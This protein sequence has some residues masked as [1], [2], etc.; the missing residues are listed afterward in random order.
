MTSRISALLA[1]I[2][3]AIG[4]SVAMPQAAQAQRASLGIPKTVD[5]HRTNVGLLILGHSTSEVGDYPTK[6]AQALG[7]RPAAVDGRN[8]VVFRVIQ[9]GDGGFLWNKAMYAPT[10]PLYNRILA[11]NPLQYCT[12]GAGN[13][14][15]VRRVKLARSLTGTDPSAGACPNSSAP[16]GLTCTWYDGAGAHTSSGFTT[17]WQKM[18]VKLALIQDTT[19]RSWPVDDWTGDGTMSVGDYF[20]TNRVPN[21][22]AWPCPGGASG[23]VGTQ[24]DWNC[25]GSLTVA[26]QSHRVYAGWLQSL[27][28]ALLNDFGAASVQH[29]FVTPKPLEFG[30]ACTTYTQPGCGLHATRTPTPSR[31]FDHFY[32]PW[33]YWEHRAVDAL[34][35]TPGLDPD[36]HLGPTGSRRM[37]LRSDDC[38]DIGVTTWTI[39]LSVG[40]PATISADDNEFVGGAESNPDGFGCLNSDHIHHNTAGGWL[41]ADVWYEGLVPYLA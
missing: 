24:I 14:W 1:A 25:D 9:G 11:S 36:I 2:V 16:V 19:N 8:Y 7:A 34:L 28:N 6:L 37:W 12:D 15:S 23:V 29:V 31:P 41:M 33:V 20:P 3:V 40:R 32:H 22:A 18:D 5:G 30:A 17:C 35:A 38:Y 10:D 26:D 13:R 21:S 39:P 27:G 4:L